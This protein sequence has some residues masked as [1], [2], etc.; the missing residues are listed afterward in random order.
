[1]NKDFNYKLV[2]SVGVPFFNKMLH[3]TII[4]KEYIPENGPII[5]CG[6]HL[7]VWDQFPVICA[8]KRVTHWMAKKEYFDSKLGPFFKAT[9]SICVDREGDASKATNEALDYLS[10]GSAIG[11]FPEGTRNK[12]RVLENKLIALEEKVNNLDNIFD[13]GMTESLLE[14]DHIITKGEKLKELKTEIIKTKNEMEEYKK[15]LKNKGIIINESDL[16]LPLH[17][18]AVS[19]AN[20]TNALIVPFG[21]TGDYTKDNNNLVVRFAEPIKPSDDLE[22][23]NELLHDEIVRLVKKNYNEYGRSK[24]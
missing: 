2:R 4:D 10:K 9:G 5:L 18:G 22:H 8:T 24:K 6:N 14:S 7:H 21:V 16:L 17:Y 15:T 12:Y 11:I 23:T 3:P 20:K 1:M 19:M 13:I